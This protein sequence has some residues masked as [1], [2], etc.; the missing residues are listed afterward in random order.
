VE[1]ARTNSVNSNN[2]VHL[3]LYNKVL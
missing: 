1:L 2:T 3:A